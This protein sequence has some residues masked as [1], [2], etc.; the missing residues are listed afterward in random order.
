MNSGR[1][2]VADGNSRPS[3]RKLIRNWLPKKR[4][5]ASAKAVIEASRIDSTTVDSA[6]TSEFHSD[7]K[8][9]EPAEDLDEVGRIPALRQ[10]ERA[11][12]Q[13]ADLFEAADDGRVERDQRE[14]R[15]EDQREPLERRDARR[16][17]ACWRGAALTLCPRAETVRAGRRWR[18]RRT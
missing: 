14:Q 17:G 16:G 6:M 12:P 4:M 5:W 10:A 3:I 18:S 13:L 7:G 8:K 1:M 2:A 11:D 15:D 9:V